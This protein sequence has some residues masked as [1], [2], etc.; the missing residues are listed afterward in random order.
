MGVNYSTVNLTVSG[1]AL[2]ATDSDGNPIYSAG[3]QGENGAVTLH[4]P[5]PADWQSLTCRLCIMAADGT[6][7]E[8]ALPVNNIIDMPLKVTILI[9]GRLKVNLKG[10][11]SDGN[12]RKTSDCDTLIVTTSATG[13]NQISS[14]YPQEFEDLTANFNTL[15]T[16]VDTELASADSASKTAQAMA[17]TASAASTNAA[18]SA[19]AAA[20]SAS[21]ASSAASSASQAESQAYTYSQNATGSATVAANSATSAA[22]SASAAATSAS[23]AAESESHA[24]SYATGASNSATAAGNSATAA[25]SSASAASASAS[26]ASQS[27]SQA[28]GY[29]QDAA[30]SESHAGSYSVGASN[31]ATAAAGSANAAANS[32]TQAAASAASVNKGY[33]GGTADLGMDGNVPVSELSSLLTPVYEHQ[34]SAWQTGDTGNGTVGV[35]DGSPINVPTVKGCTVNQSAV[36]GNFAKDSNSDGLADNFVLQNAT[37]VSCTG[38]TQTFICNAANGELLA[39]DSIGLGRKY[40]VIANVKATSINVKLHLKQDTGSYVDMAHSGDGN[41]H[42]LSAIVNI[43][44]NSANAF[45]SIQDVSAS[46]WQNISVQ[47]FRVYDMGTAAAPEYYYSYNATQMQNLVGS[48]YFEGKQS[49]VNPVVTAWNKNLLKPATGSVTANG[50]TCTVAS[51]GTITLNGTATANFTFRISPTLKYEDW[52][53]SS[54]IIIMAPGISYTHSLITTSGSYTGTIYASVRNNTSGAG[55][56][57][58]DAT[59]PNLP[60]TLLGAGQTVSQYNLHINSGASFTNYVCRLQFEIGSSATSWV[61]SQNTQQ[62]IPGTFRSNGSVYDEID[63]IGSRWVFT[64]RIASDNSVLGT[65]IVTD[66]TSSITG[67][68]TAYNG[69]QINLTDDTGVMPAMDMQY[70]VD[71]AALSLLIAA[72]VLT[73]K[74]INASGND[75]SIAEPSGTTA[76]RPTAGLVNG[77]MWYDTTLNKPIWYNATTAHW[78]DATGANV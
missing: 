30:E 39:N 69:G 48:G 27:E 34:S 38:N 44:S 10:T 45:F 17:N 54:P 41:Y 12:V 8:S 4:C 14:Y 40:F 74:A 61:Q 25:A 15:H 57:G 21:S 19:A 47:N 35:K 6:Y 62:S 77:L 28:Y 20:N 29:S 51:D 43:P 7:D 52:A 66:V 70:I 31:S 32:A 16:D 58:F 46:G 65:P 67:G 2:L 9:P 49:V 64:Q 78:Q 23:N 11:D 36:N 73:S 3:I 33:A 63:R 1:E 55:N 75:Y 37:A 5:I 18:S 42:L 60:T 72:S 13:A 22:N 59:Y 53:V 71:M 76:T 26:S 68:L 56:I 24:G 50:V